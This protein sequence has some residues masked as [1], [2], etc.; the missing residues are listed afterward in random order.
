MAFVN[1]DPQRQ[2]DPATATATGAAAAGGAAAGGAAT[3]R[4]S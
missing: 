1:R 2:H 4:L 3:R